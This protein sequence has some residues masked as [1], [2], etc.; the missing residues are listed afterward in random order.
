M[1]LE[2]LWRWTLNMEGSFSGP[3][4]HATRAIPNRPIQD[5]CVAQLPFD[6]LIVAQEGGATQLAVPCHFGLP[7]GQL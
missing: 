5:F 7:R 4:E 3:K 6:Q 1:N 2:A